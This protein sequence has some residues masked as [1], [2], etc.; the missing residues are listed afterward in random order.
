MASIFQFA[1]MI[2]MQQSGRQKL[3]RRPEPEEVTDQADHVVQYDRVM[4]TK[5]AIAYAS[6][7]EVVHRAR[8]EGM[9]R[10]TIDLA[11][12]P[13][14]YTLCLARHLGFD[15]VVGVDLS[16][17]MVEVANQ[18]ASEQGLGDRVTFRVGDATHVDGMETGRLELASFTDAA[19]HMPDLATVTRVLKEMDRM[20]KPEG[21]VMVMDLVRLRTEALT[22]RYVNTLGH[23]YVQRGLPSFFKDFHNSMYAAWTAK[24]LRQAVPRDTSRHWC[25]IVPRGLPTVQFLLGLP[26][27]RRKVFVR[28]G[29]P[30]KPEACPVPREMRGEW[31]MLRMT[32]ALASRKLIP[33]GTGT[34]V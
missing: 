3:Q 28:S 33:P 2:V 26:V 34:G 18:N 16:A 11:C 31:R 19:H 20:T 1:P 32:I 9:A 5:L 10:E 4:G 8:P 29:L 23:D 22:E 24:E 21:L 7:L 14:H 15:R 13:G 17:P 25:H 30:W 6:G 12:G 27:G